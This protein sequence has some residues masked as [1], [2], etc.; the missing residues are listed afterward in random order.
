MAPKGKQAERQA[1][2]LSPLESLPPDV[3]T[4]VAR[5]LVHQDKLHTIQT[6]SRDIAALAQASRHVWGVGGG[7]HHCMQ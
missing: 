5:Q 2:V 6:A 3:L 1:A 7:D 4:V